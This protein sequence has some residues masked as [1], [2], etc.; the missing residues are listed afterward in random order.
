[1]NPNTNELRDIFGYD[2]SQLQSL[3]KDGFIP[4]PKY[5]EK[6]AKKELNGEKSVIVDNST[7]SKL[8]KWAEKIRNKQKRSQRFR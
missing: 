2:D 1:M 8:S 6:E 3:K 7:S 5:L 4:I